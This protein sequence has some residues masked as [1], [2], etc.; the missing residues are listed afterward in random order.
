MIDNLVKKLIKM[1]KESMQDLS[2]LRLVSTQLLLR[3]MIR[4]LRHLARLGTSMRR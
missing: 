2:R 3:M 4:E 1:L